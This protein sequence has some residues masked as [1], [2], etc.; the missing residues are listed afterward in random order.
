MRRERKKTVTYQIRKDVLHNEN[1]QYTSYG[2]NVSQNG[3]IIKTIKDISLRK[4]PL[5]E[6]VKLCN[7]L[8]LS[9]IHIDDVIDDFLAR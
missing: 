7:R 4:K 3:R 5:A 9:V 8:K 6:L 2:I 1:G